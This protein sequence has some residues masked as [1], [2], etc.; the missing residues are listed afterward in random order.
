MRT[1]KDLDRFWDLAQNLPVTTRN[2]HSYLST[3]ERQSRSNLIELLFA[4][5]ES[6]VSSTIREDPAE[7]NQSQI[8]DE[9]TN[10]NHSNTMDTRE[11]DNVK[12]M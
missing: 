8:Q 3:M 4:E 1:K 7:Q 11:N 10:P 6:D 2:N 5:D 12:R 9:V